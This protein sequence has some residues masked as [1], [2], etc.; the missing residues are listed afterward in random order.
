MSVHKEN[1]AMLIPGS[2]WRCDDATNTHQNQRRN[3][4]SM[5][6]HHG[7]CIQTP[8]Y[9]VLR[10][11]WFDILGA[12]D[13]FL[14]IGPT[15]GESE[16]MKSVNTPHTQKWIQERFKKNNATVSEWTK[17]AYR[18]KNVWIRPNWSQ[19]GRLLRVWVLPWKA[20]YLSM[21]H[22]DWLTAGSGCTPASHPT[23]ASL[24]LK[25]LAVGGW[26]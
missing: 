8:A 5:I 11:H 2:K 3:T 18:I 20:V 19:F 9:T 16:M 25:G 15:V 23:T 17:N 21:Q 12:K 10:P 22:Y 4:Q 13:T 6:I 24:T 26:I 14:K 1:T 7:K